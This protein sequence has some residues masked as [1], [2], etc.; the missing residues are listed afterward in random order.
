MSKWWE[1]CCCMQC[2]WCIC[3]VI[4]IIVM[5]LKLYVRGFDPPLPLALLRVINISR[6]SSPGPTSISTNFN[7]CK[8]MEWWRLLEMFA[9]DVMWIRWWRQDILMHQLSFMFGHVSEMS[10]SEC[11]DNPLALTPGITG[12]RNPPPGHRCHALPP[13]VVNFQEVLIRVRKRV[14][15]FRKS[16][17]G[18]MITEAPPSS[19]RILNRQRV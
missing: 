16:S 7:K 19:Q 3:S 13:M 18:W 8:Q 1:C 11:Q 4:I 12:S 5:P 10:G 17:K 9:Y 2:A 15:A 14:I 6:N